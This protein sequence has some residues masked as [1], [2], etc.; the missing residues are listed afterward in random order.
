MV[1]TLLLTAGF[2]PRY[3]DGREGLPGNVWPAAAR[4]R[5]RPARPGALWP[6]LDTTA[7]EEL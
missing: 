3:T 7:G 2:L 4:L 5:V 6:R 1:M